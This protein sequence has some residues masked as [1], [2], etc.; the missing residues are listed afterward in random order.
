MISIC[1]K[2][3]VA[4]YLCLILSFVLSFLLVSSIAFQTGLFLGPSYGLDFIRIEDFDSVE[5]G[6]A[7]AAEIIHRVLW[8]TTGPPD[9]KLN[10]PQGCCLDLD[11]SRIYIADTD[12]DRVLVFSMDGEFIGPFLTSRPIKRPFDLVVGPDSLIYISQVEEKKIE[13]FN[14]KGVWQRSIPRSPR[15]KSLELKPGRMVFDRKG[16]LLVN[17]RS[18]GAVWF[19]AREGEV[20]KR[21]YVG[22]EGTGGRLLSGIAVDVNGRIYVISAQGTPVISVLDPEGVQILSFGRHGA[23]YE[24]SFSFPHSLA[25][26]NKGKMWVVDAFRHTIKVFGPDNEYLFNI[27]EFGEQPGGFVYPV[28]IDIDKDG[29]IYVLEKGAGRLQALSVIFKGPEGSE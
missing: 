8:H 22:E 26:G 12:N 19:I 27:G 6:V 29:R 23:L 25:V 1:P 4:Y 16:Q 13:V 9:N 2:R 5:P 11:F 24:D 14:K 10:R 7:E 20:L 28:D 21:Q 15:R 17:D 18:T 3:L